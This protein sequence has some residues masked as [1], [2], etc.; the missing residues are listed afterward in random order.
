MSTPIA[1]RETGLSKL[2][3]GIQ[4][5]QTH[6]FTEFF[7]KCQTEAPTRNGRDWTSLFQFETSQ[8]VL[9]KCLPYSPKGVSGAKTGSICV[10]LKDYQEVT[11]AIV[12]Q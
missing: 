4:S 11:L 9:A 7:I 5:A 8:V 1:L 3:I 10:P 12:V 6:L 2:K